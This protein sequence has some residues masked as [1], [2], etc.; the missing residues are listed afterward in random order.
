MM[1]QHTTYQLKQTAMLLLCG[2]LPCFCWAQHRS[3]TDAESI[4]EKFVLTHPKISKGNNIKYHPLS[5]DKSLETNQEHQPYYIFSDDAERTGFVI[6]SGD[7]RMPEILAYSEDNSF[8]VDNIPPNVQYWLDCY[9]EAFSRLSP[10]ASTNR[11]SVSLS[12]AHE[13]QPLLEGNSWGQGDPYN[14]LCPSYNNERCVTGCVATAMAQVMAH[15]RYPAIGKG[16]VDYRT[17]TNNIH[18]TRDF[19]KD[20]FLWG[21]MLENYKTHFTEIQAKAVSELMFSCGASVKMD[22]GTSSQGGSGAYQTSLVTAYI[23]NFSYDRDMAC[24][25]RNHCSTEDW[26]AILMHELDEGRP[27]NYAGQSLRDGGHSF[28]LDGYKTSTNSNYPDYHVNWG[29]NGT[30]NGYYQIA[31]LAPAEDGQQHTADG[32]NS[33]QQMVVGTMPEDGIDNHFRFLCTSNLHTS[34]SK[35]KNGSTI[36]VYTASLVNSSYKETNGTIAVTLT[37]SEDTTETIIADTYLKSLG[38]QQ[39]Q[40]N[41]SLNITIPSNIK[42]GQ[43]QV[44]LRYHHTGTNDYQKVFSQQYPVITISDSGEDNPTDDYYAYL[45]CSD[46]ELASTT[47]DS[48]ICIKLYELQ[49]LIEDPFIGDI[50]MILA[51]NQGKALTVF[52]DSIQPDE[53]G[54]HEIV[55]EPLSIQGCLTGDWENGKYRIYIGARKINQQSYTNISFYDITIPQ[56]EYKDFYFEADI[57]D[58]KMMIDGKTFPI[59]PSIIQDTS[60]H[61][62]N[63]ANNVIYSLTGTRQSSLRRGINIIRGKDGRMCKIFKKNK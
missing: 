25:F 55:E 51:N 35:V 26:H 43:Y 16:S 57:V 7:E 5:K 54:M 14:R 37:N 6:I 9:A 8:N 27:V 30:C 56:G 1:H 20:E 60:Y 33:S 61:L 62:T 63:T 28:V 31:N 42:E 10:A 17:L 13:V 19:S 46:F 12:T 32:F 40:R 41:Y 48:I 21:D 3:I 23:N 18:V 22:Y 39:E 11:Q 34:S 4:V 45:G 53:M 47:G 58:G 2:L 38:Y 50:R 52:G 29:W 15:Y 36:Q 24:L 59:I 49:N 44:E